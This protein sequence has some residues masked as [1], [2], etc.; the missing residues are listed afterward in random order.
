VP[1][2]QKVFLLLFVHKKKSSL[3]MPPEPETPLTQAGIAIPDADRPALLA[4]WRDLRA[5]VALL[6]EAEAEPAHVFRPD[7]LGGG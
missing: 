3:P 6:A 7:P 1:N 5:A 2:E 4:A